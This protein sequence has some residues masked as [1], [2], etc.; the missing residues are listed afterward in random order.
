[1]VVRWV[2]DGER[3]PVGPG[4]CQSCPD[5]GCESNTM[6]CDVQGDVEKRFLFSTLGYETKKVSILVVRVCDQEHGPIIQRNCHDS[7]GL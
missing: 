5:L 3:G 1:M 7:R 6:K 2:G 4:L